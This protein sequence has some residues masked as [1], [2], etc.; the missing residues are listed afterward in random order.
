MNSSTCPHDYTF[1][2]DCP[3][4]NALITPSSRS[5]VEVEFVL[6]ENA[7]DQDLAEFIAML[8]SQ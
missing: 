3:E 5:P 7:S 2:N 1:A 8:E 6:W 4:C